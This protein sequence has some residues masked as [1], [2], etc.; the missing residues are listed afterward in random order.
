[1]KTSIINGSEVSKLSVAIQLRAE[2]V[3][4]GRAGEPAL[5]AYI[6]ARERDTG[7]HPHYHLTLLFN[8]EVYGYLGDYTNRD[9]DNMATRI[10]KAWCSAIGLEYPDY[11]Y[12]PHFPKNHSAWFTRQDALTLSPDYYDFLLR[13][14]YLAKYNTK[15]LSDGYRNFGTSQL[16]T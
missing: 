11:A 4:S 10:Q 3:R 16:I 15:D 2:H 12:L 7:I 5:P 14:A 8:R 6:W 9:A 1:M 13:V